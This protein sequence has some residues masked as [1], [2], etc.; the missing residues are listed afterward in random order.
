MRL[1]IWMRWLVAGL[2]F[3]AAP[4]WAA[5]RPQEFLQ[6]LRNRDYFD[7]ALFYLDELEARPNLDAEFRQTLTYERGATL[8]AQAE[9]TRDSDAQQKLFDEARGQFEKFVKEYPQHPLAG[10]ANSEIAE[11]V[12]GKARA[13]VWQANSPNNSGRKDE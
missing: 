4:V 1:Q 12:M 13:L 7:Y 9:R 11:V 3:L 2:A 8:L 10:A 5:E 6:A